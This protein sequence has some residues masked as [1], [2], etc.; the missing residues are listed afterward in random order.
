MAGTLPPVTAILTANITAFEAKMKEAQVSAKATAEESKGSFSGAAG[1]I[2]TALA[3]VGVAVA[4]TTVAV[5][6]FG[7]KSADTFKDAGLEVAKL[8]GLTGGSAEE[9]SKWRFVADETGVGVDTLGMSYKK[10]AND[11]AG[12]TDK[13]A[14][15]GIASRDVNGHL[16]SMDDVML[17]VSDKFTKLAPGAER[18]R[19]ALD[20]FGKSGT[21]MN[22]MLGQG[23]EALKGIMSDAGA[24]G[25][26]MSQDQV[27]AAK[28]AA[29]AQRQL[30]A[31]WQGLQ[32]QVGQY[33]QPVLTAITSWMRDNMLGAIDK[34]RIGVDFLKLAWAYVSAG[35]ADPTAPNAIGGFAGVLVGLGQQA[36]K[37]FDWLKE[38]VVDTVLPA[39]HNAFDAVVG[40]VQNVTQ[41][42]SEHMD[43]AKALAIGIGVVLVGAIVAYTA[44]QIA[45]AIATAAAFWPLYLI[46][47]VIGLVAAAVYYA[48]NN[49]DW[50]RTAVQAVWAWLQV[51]GPKV[52][53]V[54][55]NAIGAFIGLVQETAWPAIQSFV[56]EFQIG[57]SVLAPK[58]KE[59]WDKIYAAV[60]TVV[61]WLTDTAW[62]AVQG[63]IRDLQIGWETLW[64]KIQTVWDNI[65]NVVSGVITW[66]QTWVWPAISAV[67]GLVV[68]HFG[69]LKDAVVAAW[70]FIVDKAGPVVDFLTNTLWPAV[71]KVAGFISDRFQTMSNVL[72]TIFS[73]ATSIFKGFLNGIITGWN[74]LMDHLSIHVQIPDFVPVYGG[75]SIDLDGKNYKIPQ[76]ASGGIVPATPGGRQV[77]VAEAGQ[78]ELIAPVTSMAD[79]IATA[80]RAA[81]RDLIDAIRGGHVIE[82]DGHQFGKVVERSVRGNELRLA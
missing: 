27:D 59:I 10:L 11:M 40:V 49:W 61:S 28:K 31:A 64:P 72:S 19:L 33:V 44:V 21:D 70:G 56:R 30:S 75:K 34:V 17:D 32:I 81:N 9:M 35:F 57:W 4:A 82:I 53:E 60:S 41:W 66:F 20:L 54:I 58:L 52:W 74:F 8:Q 77:N 69:T 43:V 63:F 38:F 45:A 46:I 24:Y 55:K 14:T 3:G 1:G 25:E 5:G 12:H 29:L 6:A 26:V 67:I 47:G 48:Y 79:M 80:V 37:L 13:L 76:L 2:G 65:Y 78:D 22:K 7:L 62:P 16:R 51:E 36:H 73:A 15:Y 18:D 23:S 42:F 71:Q 39:L 68:A 50:F